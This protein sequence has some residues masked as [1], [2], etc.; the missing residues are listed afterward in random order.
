MAAGRIYYVLRLVIAALY[1]DSCQVSFFG[2]LIG[3]VQDGR[4]T[5]CQPRVVYQDRS[6]RGAGPQPGPYLGDDDGKGCAPCITVRRVMPE[7]KPDSQPRCR[8]RAELGGR[9]V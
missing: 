1:V 9:G 4:A 5:T 2:P 7:S 6:W 8:V 3:R